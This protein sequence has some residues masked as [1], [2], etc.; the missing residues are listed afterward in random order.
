MRIPALCGAVERSLLDGAGPS[1]EYRECAAAPFGADKAYRRCDTELTSWGNDYLL[2]Y[3]TRF[4]ELS[5]SFELEP[6]TL[7][8]VGE[9]FGTLNM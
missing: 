5:P 7:E 4:V 3:D 8:L 2:R 1:W 6:G 9:A